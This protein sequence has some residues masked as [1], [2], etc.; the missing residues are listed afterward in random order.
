MPEITR[1]Y[2]MIVKMY[3]RGKEHNPPHIHFLYGE[4]NTVIDVQT[5]SVL[6]GDMPNKGLAMALEW[7][8][9][10]QGELLDMWNTQQFRKLPP[11]E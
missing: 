3:L 10:Y 11:L 9:M 7:T 5:L 4:Y 1:F 2:G 6:E 8:K